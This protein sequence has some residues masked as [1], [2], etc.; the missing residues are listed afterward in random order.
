MEKYTF[1]QANEQ[2]LKC[3][4]KKPPEFL[5]VQRRGGKLISAL[6]VRA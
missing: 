4:L 6:H 5:R 3:E 2:T 1:A